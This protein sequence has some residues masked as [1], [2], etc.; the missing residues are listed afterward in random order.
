MNGDDLEPDDLLADTTCCGGGGARGG[1]GGGAKLTDAEL[2]EVAAGGFFAMPLGGPAE[3]AGPCEISVEPEALG[4]SRPAGTV[5]MLLVSSDT[6]MRKRAWQWGHNPN[7]PRS[8]GGP[9][10]LCPLGQMNVI[11]SPRGA[12]GGADGVTGGVGA[13]GGSGSSNSN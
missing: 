12:G 13:C 9:L 7:L 11:A 5:M 10:N 2:F 1:G 6:G 3:N 4:E 8:V